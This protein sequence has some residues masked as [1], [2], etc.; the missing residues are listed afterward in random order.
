MALLSPV[1]QPTSIDPKSISTGLAALPM[2]RLTVP[3]TETAYLFGST[4]LTVTD[5]VPTEVTAPVVRSTWRS[6]AEDAPMVAL[7][8]FV[9]VHDV[10]REDNAELEITTALPPLCTTCTTVPVGAPFFAG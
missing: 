5:A 8:I 3:T 6:A 1:G 9:L 7:Q 2:V 10:D 4:V